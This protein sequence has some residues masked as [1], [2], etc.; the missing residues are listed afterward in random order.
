MSKLQT[1]FVCQSCGYASPKYLGR[2]PNC[3]T[4]NS[5]VEELSK[6][7]SKI[8]SPK[9]SNLKPTFISEVTSESKIRIKTSINEFDRVLGGGI[10]EG[11]VILIGGDPGIGKST[12]MLQMAAQIKEKVTLY[13]TGE[14]SLKQIKLRSDRLKIKINDFQLFA[15][16]NLE[17][18]LEVIENSSPEVIIIDSIQTL[19]FPQLESTPG[20][21]GQMREVATQLTRIAKNKNISIFLIGHVTKDGS[22]A[23]PRVIEHIVDTVLQ[24]EGERNYSFRILRAL[25]NRFG[26]TNEIGIFEM[27]EEGLVEV[28]NPSILFLSERRINNSGSAIVATMEGTRPLLVEVQALVSPT[29]YGMPQRTVTGFDLRR[30]QILLAV[31]EK[32]TGHKL[33]AMDVFVNIAGGLK[34]EEPAAD[35]AITLAIISSLKNEPIDS[36]MVAIGEVG[37]GGEIRNISYIEKRIQ[38]SIKLGFKNILL[39]QSNLKL[40]SSKSSTFIFVNN[41]NEALKIFKNN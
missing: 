15:E 10:V 28:E 20:S 24:F 2:C 18:I 41:L 11:S 32:R 4:W 22:I 40:M 6:E 25:K 26:S 12:L 38:E 27:N 14:E 17:I 35:L 8:K 31:I 33:G 1:K 16:T 13:V 39:P 34:I 36:T 21:V 9:S 5:F 23:G 30:L 29:Y 19:F 7:K 37:L 3:E